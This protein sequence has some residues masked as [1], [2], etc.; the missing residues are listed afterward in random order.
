M[1][2]ALLSTVATGLTFYAFLPYIRSIH[3]G[4]TRP[5]VFSWVIW[6]LT[7]FLVFFAQLAGG[8]GAGAWVIGL[9]GVITLYIAVLAC[10]KRAD[11]SITALDWVFFCGAISALPFWVATSDP[12]V[13]VVILTV[14]DVAGFG[15]TVRKVWHRP[16]E[17]SAGFFALFTVRN[18]LVILALEKVTVTTALFPAA[19]GVACL[20][21]IALMGW[22]RRVLR[23]AQA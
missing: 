15:P 6:G 5:H 13:A 12:L 10:V 11:F 2:R 23:A 19:V 21:L 9:S 3:Q 8:G 1:F 18:L 14:V 4:R 17:E 22:R 20:L 7:T 16:Q